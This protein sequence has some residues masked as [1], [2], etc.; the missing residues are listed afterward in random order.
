MR[1]SSYRISLPGQ[2][3]HTGS[4]RRPSKSCSIACRA[5]RPKQPLRRSSSVRLHSACSKR[6]KGS[7]C[8]HRYSHDLQD[9]EQICAIFQWDEALP[10][11]CF[12]HE[13]VR[14]RSGGSEHIVLSHPRSDARGVP[15]AMPRMLKEKKKNPY[16]FSSQLRADQM[17]SPP[18]EVQVIYGLFLD[19]QQHACVL[20]ASSTCTSRLTSWHT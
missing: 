20:T 14:R 18:R 10:R 4:M 5:R 15:C 17:P 7:R 8:S 3:P 12:P 11:C 13:Q 2:P 19:W 9:F 16:I 6:S 1:R